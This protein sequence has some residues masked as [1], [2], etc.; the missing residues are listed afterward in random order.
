MISKRLKY[1]VFPRILVIGGGVSG[2]L[3]GIKL[4]QR[5]FGNFTILEAADS[6]GGTWR[7]NTYPGVA[8][9]DPA[10]LYV[11]SFEPNPKLTHFFASG[12]QIREYYRRVAEKYGV[13]PHV[14]CKSRVTAAHWETD[15]WSV[16][17]DNGVTLHGDVLISAVGRLDHPSVPKIPGLDTFRGDKFHS[18]RWNHGAVLA[19]RRVGIIGTG[20]S[21]TQMTEP[22]SHVASQ[23]TLFQRTPQWVMTVPNDPLPRPLLFALRHVPLA[24]RTYYHYLKWKT[25]K[26][27]KVLRDGDRAE[28]EDQARESLRQVLDPGLRNRLTPDYAP[29]CKRM[30]NSPNFYQAVQRENVD[31]VTAGI[32]HVDASGVTT[33]D[34]RH[35]ELDVLVLA[36]GFKAH[37]FLR[38][39]AL[40]G[41]DG[42]TLED[43]WREGFLTY[44]TVGIPHMPNFFMI[45]GPYTPG[46]SGSI[47]AIVEIQ[48]SYVISCVERIA[49]DRVSLAPRSEKADEWVTNVRGE[50]MGT[51]WA[52]GG[53]NSYYLD[54]M[55][56]PVNN[57]ASRKEF[58]RDLHSPDHGDYV[59]RSLDAVPWRLNEKAVS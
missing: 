46:A 24:A 49:H 52:T 16:N 19:E 2:I 29:G 42:V 51:V 39:M 18:A 4:L 22:L 14:R 40:E 9:D 21:G 10:C 30:V 47:I 43:V 7:Q 32:D 58:A 38:P 5:G 33:E 48:V 45:N 44:R 26:S 53:C 15:H 34:G 55:G 37:D 17:L 31:V 57:P 54:E 20:S 35:H 13:L 56:V 25:A 11:Y 1:K 27:T 59:V 3:T 41:E 12:D 8:C 23:L 50:A 28:Y 6:V 36:T